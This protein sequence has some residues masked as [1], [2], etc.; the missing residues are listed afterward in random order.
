MKLRPHVIHPGT[1]DAVFHLAF[2]AINSDE[3]SAPMVPRFIEGLFVAADMPYAGHAQ[4]KGFAS[5][6]KLGFK[7]LRA[8]IVMLDE[9]ETRPVLS[10][11]GF[12][13]AEVAGASLLKPDSVSGGLCSKLVWRP[14]VNILTREEIKKVIEG[15][16]SETGAKGVFAH[17]QLVEV[18]D[19]ELKSK[20]HSS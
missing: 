6:K 13:C 4:L 5:A 3:L 19:I 15:S 11:S 18:S 9:K 1:L 12:T 8:D 20:L 14:A 10:V 2:A 16:A 17:A 7:E